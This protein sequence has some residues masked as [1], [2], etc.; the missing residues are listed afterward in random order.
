MTAS[1]P[2]SSQTLSR[3][4][5]ALELVAEAETPLSISELS[6][7][8][9][10][11]RSIVYRI[12][13]TLEDHGLVVRNAAGDL[14]LGARLAALARNV[15]HDLQSAALPELTAISNEFGMTAFLA[16][17]DGDEA[18]TLTSVEPRHAVAAVAQRPGTRHSITRGAPGR[19]IRSQLYPAE[20]APASFETSHDEVITGLSAV[21]VPLS[22]PGQ[23]PAALA[24]VYLT[25]PADVPAI[26]ARL[27]KAAMAI[28]A[29]LS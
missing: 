8:L 17:L 4:L 3:G 16:T 6:G 19:A 21:A 28:V 20:Y 24:V 14:E 9:G 15:S 10:L 26:G 2:A 27:Q 25:Q 23:R 11:H 12:V 13:R 5:T 29:E 1:K 22:A 7:R 18:V